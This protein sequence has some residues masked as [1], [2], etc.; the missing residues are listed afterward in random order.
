MTIGVLE[1]VICELERDL[2]VS[3]QEIAA[4]QLRGEAKLSAFLKR[5]DED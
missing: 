2:T 1:S 3:T 5:L 4:E